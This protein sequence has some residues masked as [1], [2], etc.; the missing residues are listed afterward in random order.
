M[1]GG[2]WE[3]ASALRAG[4]SL[5]PWCHLFKS[6]SDSSP[7]APE[8]RP[9]ASPATTLA[10]CQPSRDQKSRPNSSLTPEGQMARL[11]GRLGVFP[12]GGAGRAVWRKVRR[13]ARTDGSILTLTPFQTPQNRSAESPFV[14]SPPLWKRPIPRVLPSGL[15]NSR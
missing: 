10:P 8:R 14:E 1:L 15:G 9:F 2:L 11:R 13:R 4:R 6:V 7:N 5:T 12:V 3:R